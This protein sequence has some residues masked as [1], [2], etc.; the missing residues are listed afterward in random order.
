MKLPNN[1][2][3]L[4]LVLLS[5]APSV[6]QT[7]TFQQLE[8]HVHY[9]NN[10]LK[11]NESQA[12]LLPVLQSETFS[13]DEKYQA[14]ILLSYTYKRVSDYQATLQFLEAARQ[15]AGQ[16]VRK[17]QKLAA[18]LAQ[19][20]FAYF[21]IHKYAKA[22]S[23]MKVLEKSDFRYIDLENKSKLVMQQGYSLFLAKRYPEA[24]ATYD[25]A[26]GWMRVSSPCDLPMIYVKKMQL[27]AAMNR[28]DM[29]RMA[30][31]QS[32][33]S[34][35]SCVILKYHLYAYGELLDI[36]KSRNDLAGIAATNQKV[37]SL[38]K[39]YA[40]AENIA[41]LH[42]QK[43]TLLLSEKDRSLQREQSHR[44]Y[45][46]VGLWSAVLVALSLL[47][48]LLMYYRKQRMKEADFLRMKTE[49]ETYMTLIQ[50][51]PVYKASLE[52]MSLNAL[53]DRQREVL[54]YMAMGMANKEIADK[55]FVSENTVKYHIK[56]I[57][58]LLEIKDRKDL[59]TKLNK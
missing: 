42:N 55:L 38:N 32:I 8:Q 6:G 16:T 40:Q 34:A 57:Y 24:E 50:A 53:S 12:L 49:L 54:A 45:L 33:H 9:L 37:D 21:D 23:L 51:T 46:T 7:R 3:Y 1:Y 39:I 43:E 58:Q 56:N 44:V 11:Y 48:W 41:A 14:A 10:A 29:L 35:D 26:I 17:N 31:R 15:F 52:K 25:N 59:L 30:L 18:I 19:E 47:A 27:Y 13:A 4:M 28:M 36:Y 20:A 2:L 22:D 5:F